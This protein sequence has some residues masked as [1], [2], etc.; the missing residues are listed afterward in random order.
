MKDLYYGFKIVDQV[1]IP[2]AICLELLCFFSEEIEDRIGGVAILED[3]RRGMCSEVDARLF[4]IFGQRSI[5]NGLKVG[6]GVRRRG[7]R[8]KG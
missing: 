2:I 8:Q 6:R 1:A 4:N 7:H 5:E 3:L